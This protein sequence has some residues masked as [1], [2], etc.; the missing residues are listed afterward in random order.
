[1]PNL[2]LKANKDEAKQFAGCED[3]K[4]WLAFEVRIP[5]HSVTLGGLLILKLN[6]KLPNSTTRSIKNAS[7][8]QRPLGKTWIKRKGRNVLRG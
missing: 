5:V 6:S 2:L 1:M 8:T 4:T 7:L 3:E